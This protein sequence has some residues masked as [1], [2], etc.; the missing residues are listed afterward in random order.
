MRQHKT[1]MPAH[2]R[3]KPR[4]ATSAASSIMDFVGCVWT[5]RSAR[6]ISTL[7]P[8]HMFVMALSTVGRV[9]AG[10]QP[11]LEPDQRASDDWMTTEAARRAAGCRPPSDLLEWAINACDLAEGANSMWLG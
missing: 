2:S 11:A 6:V 5:I 1:R 10:P 7:P 8:R 3:S 9:T 4:Q